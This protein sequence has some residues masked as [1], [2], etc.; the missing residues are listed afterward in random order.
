MKIDARRMLADND[1]EWTFH[2]ELDVMI[3]VREW[4]TLNETAYAVSAITE[5]MCQLNRTSDKIL[6]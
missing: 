1:N 6:T 2:T 3:N 5:H 4:P